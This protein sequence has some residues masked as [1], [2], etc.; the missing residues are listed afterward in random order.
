LKPFLIITGIIL[1]V[2]LIGWGIWAIYVNTPKPLTEGTVVDR[3][4]VQAHEESYMRAEQ[5]PETY[6]DTECRTTFDANGQSHQSCHPVTRTRLR[7]IYV[8]D[9]RHV[10]DDWDIRIS[11]CSENRQGERDCREE[12][13][14][15]SQHIF[16]QC[17]N[18]MT[19]RR[20]TGCRAQ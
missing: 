5:I 4:F 16:D 1:V 18:D 11:G 10:P 19:W 6:V 8:P 15:V 9:T 12:W 17:L 20:E 3:R 14:D 7:T 2:L 13:I